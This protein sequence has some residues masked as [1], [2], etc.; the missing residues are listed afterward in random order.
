M[1]ILAID[2]GQKKVGIALSTSRLTEPYKVIRFNSIKTLIKEIGEIINKEQIEKLVIGVSDGEMGEESK[3][4][5]EKLKK[6]LKLL[7]DFQDE[8]LT[9]QKAQELSFEAGIKRKKRKELE[10]AYSAALIL[11]AYLD[12]N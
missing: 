11:E 2:Y 12:S 10:D 9:T 1:R 3:R 5:G 8:T 6:E 7:V 4:F